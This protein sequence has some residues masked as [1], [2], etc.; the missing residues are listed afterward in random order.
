MRLFRDR[1]IGGLNYISLSII[2]RITSFSKE[3]SLEIHQWMS[4]YDR[5]NDLMIKKI[6]I[7]LNWPL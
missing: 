3:R 1:Y 6:T 2:I 4:K 7:I 5:Q